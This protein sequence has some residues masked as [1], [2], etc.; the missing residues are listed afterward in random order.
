MTWCCGTEASGTPAIMWLTFILLWIQKGDKQLHLKWMVF[1]VLYPVQG[2]LQLVWR[3]VSIDAVFHSMGSWVLLF[4]LLWYISFHSLDKMNSL[5]LSLSRFHC[6]LQY[7]QTSLIHSWSCFQMLSWP[8]QAL[9]ALSGWIR[10]RCRQGQYYDS[11]YLQLFSTMFNLQCRTK[12]HGL[13]A[14]VT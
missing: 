14:S 12:Q 10:T 13:K 4:L 7:I 1:G 8:L 6:Y 3:V 2:V 5:C 9:L 11:S